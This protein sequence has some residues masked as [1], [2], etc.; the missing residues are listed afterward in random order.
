[1]LAVGTGVTCGHCRSAR[2]RLFHIH[3]SSALPSVTALIPGACKLATSLSFLRKS[4][5]TGRHGGR[6]L[7][8]SRSA[9][10]MQW[11]GL[12]HGPESDSFV[13]ATW[14]VLADGLAQ[15]GG[16]IHVRS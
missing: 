11:L 9:A 12:P 16:W 10:Q 14:N 15:S 5:A 6:Q 2:L 1:M 8:M 7:A 4:G 3:I 13:V